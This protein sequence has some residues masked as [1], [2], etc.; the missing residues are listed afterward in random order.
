MLSYLTLLVKIAQHAGYSAS[1]LFLAGI[2]AIAWILMLF[3]E[4]RSEAT[5]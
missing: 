5:V 4:S 2:A 1:F 3:S